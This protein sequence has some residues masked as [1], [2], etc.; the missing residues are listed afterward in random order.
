LLLKDVFLTKKPLL[1]V[2][3]AGCI[4]YWSELPALDM[5]GLND[6][7][8]P[9]HPPKN[10]GKGHLAHEL[11]N[12]RYVLNKNPDIIIFHIGTTPIFRSGKEL[13][14]MPEFYRRYIP[15]KI[16]ISD[17]YLALVYFNKYSEKIGI[18]TL[19]SKII[20]PG[21]LFKRK[22][23]IAYLNKNNK[24]VVQVK[25]GQPLYMAFHSNTIQKWAVDV[26]FFH[27]DKILSKLEQYNNSIYN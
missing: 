19:Q 15:I 26:K 23:S 27:S 3:A 21:F 16:K 24:L 13:E 12:G 10:I 5:L 14:K 9:R 11:G 4:P 2:T 1:A 8:L 25:N 7:Y 20:I 6:Y 22:N 18:Q 17:N